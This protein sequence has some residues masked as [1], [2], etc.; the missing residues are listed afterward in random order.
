MNKIRLE[1][2]DTAN[3]VVDMKI[4]IISLLDL[5]HKNEIS[6]VCKDTDVE[7]FVNLFSHRAE[8]YK[9][10]SN[11]LYDM[12][13]TQTQLCLEI[14]IAGVKDGVYET[15]LMNRETGYQ[16]PILAPDAVYLSVISDIPIFISTEL[17]KRQSSKY[18]GTTKLSLPVNTLSVTMLQ[19]AL[20]NAIK[21][22]NYELAS[23]LRDELKRRKEGDK[24]DNT[25][26]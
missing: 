17:M 7:K 6:I 11:V 13:S 14:N 22:E 23:N 16:L 18:T 15:Y 19:D 2:H 8:Q 3:V 20:D 21:N 25:T 26:E 24:K 10:L 12:I 4:G 9:T 1:Y 5:K